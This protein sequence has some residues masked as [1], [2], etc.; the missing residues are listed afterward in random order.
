MNGRR[1][2]RR[3][4]CSIILLFFLFILDTAVP[5]IITTTAT[6]TATIRII[7]SSFGG[8]YIFSF[9]ICD[10]FI[11]EITVYVFF[12]FFTFYFCSLP[13]LFP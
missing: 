1:E 4:V 13:L 5:G 12:L 3:R 8:V 6:T 10:F 11:P 9:P 2:E 7:F